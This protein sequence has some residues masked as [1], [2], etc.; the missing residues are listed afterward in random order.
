MNCRSKISPAE[1][2]SE[3]K[4]LTLI[5]DTRERETAALKRRLEA[6]G[7]PVIRE[8]LDF[9]DYSCRTEHFDF[10][11]CFGIERKMSLDEIAQNLTRSRERFAREFERAQKADARIYILVEN[12]SYEKV[13]RRDY[14]TKE[15]PNALIASLFTWQARYNAKLIFCRSETTPYIIREILVR[16]ARHRLEK[17]TEEGGEDGS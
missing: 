2:D 4:T 5:C 11:D 14:R 13:Y 15:H 9:A 3:L 12:G 8:K 7:L 16:E 6:I 10:S 1:I 17:I